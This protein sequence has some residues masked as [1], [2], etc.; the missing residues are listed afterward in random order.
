VHELRH[1]AA[2]STRAL[3]LASWLTAPWRVARSLL[4]DPASSSG[5]SGHGT[6]FRRTQQGQTR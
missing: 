4:T 1:H 2:G 3:L 6:P 5:K